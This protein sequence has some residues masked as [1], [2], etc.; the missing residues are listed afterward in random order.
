MERGC[1]WTCNPRF[2]AATSNMWLACSHAAAPPVK[3][4]SEPCSWQRRVL[5][6]CPGDKICMRLLRTIWA[7]WKRVAST[8]RLSMAFRTNGPVQLYAYH[9]SLI[10]NLAK[11]L[12]LKWCKRDYAFERFC[13]GRFIGS[14]CR[15][16]LTNLSWAPDGGGQHQ[17]A[18]LE[19]KWIETKPW[20][21]RSWPHPRW[22]G[23]IGQCLK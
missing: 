3:S 10:P 18:A 16:L 12:I 20:S 7:H 22:P 4:E 19:N 11:K 8:L 23:Q 21:H 6:S 14:V 9:G 17:D 13:T 2:A 5:W 15:L 1:R